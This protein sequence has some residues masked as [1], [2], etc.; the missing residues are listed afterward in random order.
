MTRKWMLS[1][2]SRRSNKVA[3]DVS[4]NSRFKKK[5][6]FLKIS[7]KTTTKKFKTLEETTISSLTMMDSGMLIKE[8]KF[9]N[10]KTTTKKMALLRKRNRFNRK[11][12]KL[13]SN[14]FNHRVLLP[15]K[16][17]KR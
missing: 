6:L 15:T 3:Q 9:G 16:K 14:T 5:T 12:I 17:S 4:I 11:E 2:K 1:M 8:V 13:W 10:M 7:I